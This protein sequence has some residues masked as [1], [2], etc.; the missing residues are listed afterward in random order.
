MRVDTAPNLLVTPYVV[1]VDS[2]EQAP[3]VFS[4]LRADAASGRRPLLVRTVTRGLPAGDYSLEGWEAG[5]AVER[6][7]LSDL[8]NTL[9]QARARFQRE[10]DRLASY[11]YAAVVVEAE[12]STVLSS[13]PPRSQLNPKTVFRSVIAWQQR[14]PTI[15]WWFVAGRKMG[16]VVT[17]RILERW[18]RNHAGK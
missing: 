14:A 2:R 6:K 11:T 16:E 5:V 17:L 3:Y 12:W 4:G 8:F 15:H 10:L 7:S 13:P 18:W 9:G 1:V